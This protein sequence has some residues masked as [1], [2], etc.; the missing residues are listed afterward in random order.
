MNE[1][2]VN[3]IKQRIKIKKIGRFRKFFGF[4]QYK[5]LLKLNNKFIEWYGDL[6]TDFTRLELEAIKDFA[7]EHSDE[8][9]QGLVMNI[10]NKLSYINTMELIK[11][12]KVS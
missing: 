10:N 3:K 8:L 5:I 11:K 9:P 1:K 7:N 12:Q 4:H 6:Q 2:E